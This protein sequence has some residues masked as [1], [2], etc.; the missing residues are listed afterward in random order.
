MMP[1][2]FVDLDGVLADFETHYENHFGVRPDKK[3]DNVDWSKVRSFP[4]FYR[5]MPM[6][7]DWRVLWDFVSQL[8]RRPVI[9]TGFPRSIPEAAQDKREFCWERLGD[10]D[11]RTCHS[12]D[13]SIQCQPGDILID[14]WEKY[15]LLWVMRGGKWITHISAQD[16]VAQLLE[17]GIGL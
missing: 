14:D 4:G 7:P 16:S 11:V 2:V 13:K 10:V 6:M 1:Q 17:M 8:A 5:T 9:L 15:R 3:N 12:R